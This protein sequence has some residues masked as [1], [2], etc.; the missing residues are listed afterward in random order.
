MEPSR[1]P[2]AAAG[3]ME[4][5]QKVNYNQPD[6]TAT[7]TSKGMVGAST[8]HGFIRLTMG[9]KFSDGQRVSRNARMRYVH[10]NY[11]HHTCLTPYRRDLIF[12]GAETVFPR[13]LGARLAKEARLKK[14]ATVGGTGQEPSLPN[15]PCGLENKTPV[16]PPTAENGNENENK[17]ASNEEGSRGRRTHGW[18]ALGARLAKEARLKK[19][20]TVGGTGQEPSLPNVPCGLENKTPVVPPTAENENENKTASNEEGSRGHRSHSWR[21]LSALLA[22]E[23]CLKKVATVGG[24]GQEPSLPNLPCSLE[25]KAPV[26]HPTAENENKTASNEEGSRGRRSRGWRALSAL[27]AKEAHLKK[28]ATVGGTGQEPSLPNLPCSSENKAPVVPPTAENENKTASIEEGSR[29]CRRRGWSIEEG[30]RGCRSRGWRA[31]RALLAKEARLKKIATVGGT[32]QEP[33]LPNLPCSSENKAPVVPPTAENENKTASNEEGSR[34]RRSRGWR[35]CSKLF[36]ER[37]FYDLLEDGAFL[38]RLL[39]TQKW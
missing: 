7:G 30:S 38:L 15:V 17:T 19:M 33:S 18:R 16:V 27:L 23:A 14:M 3:T 37:R 39:K 6:V 34:G 5:G 36:H 12:L 31:L 8:E 25:N 26:V 28:M 32:G 22:K 2:T 24:T 29:G 13:A 10:F 1:R 20:A 4:N 21:V 35:Y 11:L 9:K